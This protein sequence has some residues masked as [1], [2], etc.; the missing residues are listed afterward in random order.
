MAD[1]PAAAGALSRDVS[2]LE[3]L[4][5]GMGV[6]IS[7]IEL[8]C[9]VANHPSGRMSGS[10]SATALADVYARRLQLGDPG[11]EIR[12][13]FD[14]FKRRVPALAAETD[15]LYGACHIPGGKEPSAQFRALS[16]GGMTPPREVQV[17]TVAATFAHVWRAKRKA[18]GRPIGLNFLRKIERPLL[19]GL[20]GAM[21]GEAD[22][23]V[24]GAGD[25]SA[26][27]ALLDGLARNEPVELPVQVATVPGGT[28]RIRLDPR[29]LAGDAPPPPRPAFL[30]IVSSH[31]QAEG[32]AASES[33]RPDGFIIEGHL[34]GGHNAP[35]RS[36]A[37]D[38][39]GFCVYG[40]EDEA[41][42]DAVAALGLPFWVAGGRGQP[43]L[44]GEPPRRQIGTLFA[45][46]AESGMA[47]EVRR[48]TLELIWKNRV[49][50]VD[51]P[52]ASPSGYPFKVALVPGT[53]GDPEVYAARRRRCNL[54]HLRGW[55]PKGDAVIGLCPADDTEIYKNSGGA[56][57]RAQGAMCLCNGLMATCGLGQ[58]DEAP[59]VTLGD[60]S[61]VRAVQ[62]RLRRIEYT[63]AEAIAYLLGGGPNALPAGPVAAS[64]GPT[65]IRA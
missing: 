55:R 41:D 46:A 62:K 61:P 27:P 7:G 51:D 21:L 63:A 1:S 17:L 42:L 4:V 50:T 49:E 53:I 35:P 34:A 18:P 12:A 44:P 57:W 2:F 58:P 37:K 11:G 56:A 14:A 23:I 10:L 29:E 31:L 64:V 47:P 5:G 38:A 19:Y 59:V 52:K 20:Y 48:R 43:C 25:P 9:A 24:M 39:K 28:H 13:A 3:I 54:G 15:R 26:I 6:E 8:V 40:P 30:A 33:T 32:L 36:N 22:W 16:M 60:I 65:D 45:L